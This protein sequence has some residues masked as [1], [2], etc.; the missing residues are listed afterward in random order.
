MPNYTN[1]GQYITSTDP[2]KFSVKG[3]YS[4]KNIMI[5]GCTG[6][7]GTVILE[8]FLRSIP[9]IGKI[10]IMVRAKKNMKPMDRIKK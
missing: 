8:K 6:F 4:G 7:L 9:D 5:T 3:Y 1:N 2:P 10:F